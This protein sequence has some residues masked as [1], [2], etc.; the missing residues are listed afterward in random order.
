MAQIVHGFVTT[1][2]G[3]YLLH[4]NTKARVGPLY[5]IVSNNSQQS[6]QQVFIKSNIKKSSSSQKWKRKR[7]M[8]SLKRITKSEWNRMMERRM[9]RLHFAPNMCLVRR[10]VAEGTTVPVTT[11]FTVSTRSYQTVKVGSCTAST[12]GQVLPYL[13]LTSS[14]AEQEFCCWKVCGFSQGNRTTTNQVCNYLFFN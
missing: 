3:K 8:E 7:I 10:R 12:H 1:S 2:T 9:L 11:I 5:S 4:Y 13:Q 14:A 6:Q